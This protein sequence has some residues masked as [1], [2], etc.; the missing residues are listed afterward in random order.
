MVHVSFVMKVTGFVFD[1]QFI[2][3]VKILFLVFNSIHGGMWF[4]IL[5][6]VALVI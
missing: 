2:F 6:D 5:N 3:T 4:E 1:R